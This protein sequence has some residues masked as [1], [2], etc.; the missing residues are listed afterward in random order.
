MLGLGT[1]SL[2]TRPCVFSSCRSIWILDL[3]L[4][5]PSFQNYNIAIIQFIVLSKNEIYYFL[6]VL[7]I[8]YIY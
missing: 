8:A 2:F 3:V 4:I 7:L 1:R 6:F 5:G